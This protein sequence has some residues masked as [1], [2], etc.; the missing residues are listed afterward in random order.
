MIGIN[1]DMPK[2]CDDCPCNN[3]YFGEDFIEARCSLTGKELIYTV[4]EDG[5]PKKLRRRKNCPMVEIILPRKNGKIWLRGE[6]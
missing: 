1:I 2:F 6:E 4:D 3:I 5:F